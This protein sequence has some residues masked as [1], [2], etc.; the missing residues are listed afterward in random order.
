MKRRSVI[1]TRLLLGVALATGLLYTA[2]SASAQRMSITVPFS[3]TANHQ[4]MP[5][6]LYEVEMLSNRFMALRNTVTEE[7]QVFMVHPGEGQ[8]PEEAPGRLIFVRTGQEF[9]LNQ[10]RIAGKIMYSDLVVQHKADQEMAMGLTPT[11][12]TVEVA[13]K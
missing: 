2:A 8:N 3:F 12:S 4:L 10:V 9:H 13:F 7:T 1:L 6:G 5:A 11:G